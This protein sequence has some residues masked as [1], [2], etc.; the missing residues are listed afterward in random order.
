MGKKRE[1]PFESG[2]KRRTK[3]QIGSAST[4]KKDGGGTGQF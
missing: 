4:T 1:R 2:P 3:L